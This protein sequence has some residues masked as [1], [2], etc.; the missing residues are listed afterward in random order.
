MLEG[1]CQSWPIDLAPDFDQGR[2]QRLCR[3]HGTHLLLLESL[4]ELVRSAHA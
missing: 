1:E 3:H 2:R 4:G